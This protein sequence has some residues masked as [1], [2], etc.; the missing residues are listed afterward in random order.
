MT[1]PCRDQRDLYRQ[2]YRQG[3]VLKSRDLS[4]Q[5]EDEEQ[6][7]WWHNRAVHHAYGI[8][9]GCEAERTSDGRAICVEAGLAYDSFGRPLWFNS[10][11]TVRVPADLHREEG[12]HILFVCKAL[13]NGHIRGRRSDGA[14]CGKTIENGV[15]T[16][17]FKWKPVSVFSIRD[18]VAIAIVDLGPNGVVNGSVHAGG[19]RARSDRN[20]YLI[21]GQT[22]LGQTA[23]EVW[24]EP[25]SGLFT[26]GQFIT[27]GVQVEIDT[28]AA[29]FT[30]EPIYVAQ[31]APFVGPFISYV[32]SV[33]EVGFIFRIAFSY[34]ETAKGPVFLE[35]AEGLEWLSKLRQFV[36]VKWI[37]LEPIAE[38]HERTK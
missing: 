7:R 31:T 30:G 1:Q 19:Y 37:G 8:V 9:Y 21:N 35:S 22:I 16:G 12:K 38:M 5:V 18:G 10:S 24:K 34:K 6:L 20:P 15:S 17:E 2:Q 14:W 29:G 36:A 26:R 11:V 32:T 27:W 3:Q 33:S 23:W 25:L 13:N 4:D 28:R